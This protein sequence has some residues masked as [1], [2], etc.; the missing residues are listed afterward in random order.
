MVIIVIGK[1]ASAI[2]LITVLLV[3]LVGVL[4]LFNSTTN[5][6]TGAAAFGRNSLETEKTKIH[7]FI[8]EAHC[9]NEDRSIIFATQR[10]FAIYDKPPFRC[11][12]CA[13]AN[14]GP[15]DC[16]QKF[17]SETPCPPGSRAVA[18][19][20]RCIEASISIN[21]KYCQQITTTTTTI[22]TS[23]TTEP[24]STTTTTEQITTTTDSSTTTTTTETSTTTTTVPTTTTTT[25]GPS[26]S[27]CPIAGG[28]GG[29]E[30]P[31]V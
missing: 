29:S 18:R 23:T 13:N 11:G 9:E 26:P 10:H 3:A 31:P 17:I 4:F 24:S 20:Q 15:A 30:C 2:V 7:N 27:P 14:V 6:P 28:G 22:S 12:S 25:I 5:E 1:K 8:C 21:S 16:E 19:V